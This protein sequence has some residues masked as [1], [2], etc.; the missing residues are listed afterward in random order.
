MR[1]CSYMYGIVMNFNQMEEDVDTTELWIE[2][3]CA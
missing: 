1:V 3:D 2:D